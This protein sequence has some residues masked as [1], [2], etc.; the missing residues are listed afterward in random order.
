MRE[1]E[2]GREMEKEERERERNIVVGFT[3]WQTER[4][5]AATLYSVL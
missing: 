3:T 5:F 1:R 2:R 4:G